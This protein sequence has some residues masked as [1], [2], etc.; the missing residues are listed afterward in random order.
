MAGIPPFLVPF[1]V[2]ASASLST[3]DYPVAI[4]VM[5]DEYRNTLYDASMNLRDYQQAAVRDAIAFL[6][7]GGERR[8]YA[9]PTG[10]GKSVIELAVL[11]AFP[12]G[13]LVTPRLEIIAGM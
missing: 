1:I 3:A 6:N 5:L 2:R 10:S 13:V 9:A 4:R 12:G 8:C 7:A 11:D